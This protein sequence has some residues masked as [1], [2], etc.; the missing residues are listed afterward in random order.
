VPAIPPKL[1]CLGCHDSLAEGKTFFCDVCM[2]PRTGGSAKRR[3]RRPFRLPVPRSFIP[4]VGDLAPT[5]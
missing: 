4:P 2:R 1:H 5:W 3:R